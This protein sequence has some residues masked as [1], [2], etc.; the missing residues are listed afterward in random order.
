MATKK[1][2]QLGSAIEELVF[3]TREALAAPIATELV[4]PAPTP[5]LEE[6]LKE[7]A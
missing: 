6:G 2:K 3:G 4:S 5:T 7:E 1:R